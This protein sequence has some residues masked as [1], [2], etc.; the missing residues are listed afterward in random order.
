MA[1]ITKTRLESVLTKSLK[2][3]SPRFELE[4]LPGGKLSGSIISDTFEGLSSSDRQKRIW[5]ALDDEWGPEAP[6]K[7][8]TLLAYSTQ[9]W[10]V[11]LVGTPQERKV[12]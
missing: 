11:D 12:S 6:N 1:T 4:S 3:K 5:D 9:E 7:I 10:D 2:L 8:G